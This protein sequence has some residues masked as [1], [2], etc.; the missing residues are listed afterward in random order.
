MCIGQ[1]WQPSREVTV[2]EREIKIIRAVL[3]RERVMRQRVFRDTPQGQRKVAEIDGALAALD[4]IAEA[5]VVEPEQ[6]QAG[7][8]V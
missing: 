3:N 5:L 4:L 1:Y 7:L 8:F 6:T 2:K